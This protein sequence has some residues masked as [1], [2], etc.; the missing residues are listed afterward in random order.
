MSDDELERVIAK[1]R[2]EYAEQLP[3]TIAQMEALWQSIVTAETPFVRQRELVR[4]AHSISGSGTTFG[5]PGA[6]RAAHEL[7]MFLDQIGNSGTLPAAE[8]IKTVSALLAAL[9]HAVIQR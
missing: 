7:E 6:T 1:L 5:I 3:E 4:M 8:E 2:A 9:K